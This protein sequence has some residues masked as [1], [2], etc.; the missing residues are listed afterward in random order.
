DLLRGN[1]EVDEAYIGGPEVGIRG[2]RQW[3]DKAL[4]VAAVELRGEAPVRVQ[5]EPDASAG[6]LTGFV[7]AKV[8]SN[9]AS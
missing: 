6:S 1:V 2:G 9:E 8:S 7:Q 4:V 5:V 3:I